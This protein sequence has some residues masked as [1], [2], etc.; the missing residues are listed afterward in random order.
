MV[1]SVTDGGRGAVEGA[2]LGGVALGGTTLGGVVLGGALEVP[3]IGE[4]TVAL[5][6]MTK[7]LRLLE[8]HT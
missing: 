7:F 6:S 5:V 2:A 1:G 3:T 8:P 4:G